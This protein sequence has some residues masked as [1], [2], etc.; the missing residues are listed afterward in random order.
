MLGFARNPDMGY[1]DVF[2]Y[3]DDPAATVCTRSWASA[4]RG[5]GNT[6]RSR[7]AC[8]IFTPEAKE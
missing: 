7:A 1:T 3:A 6:A 2:L 4:V 5:A 8:P